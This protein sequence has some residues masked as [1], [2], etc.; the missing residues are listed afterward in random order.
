[1]NEPAAAVADHIRAGL[2]GA[3]TLA[4]GRREGMDRL[5]ADPLAPALSFWAAAICLPAFVL[6]RL[7]AW[8]T[9]TAPDQPLRTLLAGILLYIIGWA[10]Y[11][12]ASHRAV[13]AL[14]RSPLWPRY[15]VAWNWCNVVQYALF[16]AASVPALLGVP[17]WMQQAL[18]LIALF[19][20]LWLEWFAARLA[21]QASAM[22]AFLLVGLD[23]LIGLVLGG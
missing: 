2:S 22:A 20:A 10:G 17:D 1:M 5:P 7:M 21:L 13:A 8:S 9:T 16:L 11:A 12:V 4:L 23:V 6:L 18:S 15:I 14:G 3:F 19:W